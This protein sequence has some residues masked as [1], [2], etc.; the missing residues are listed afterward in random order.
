[1]FEKALAWFLGLFVATLV[2]AIARDIIP[3]GT[4]TVKSGFRVE[5][6]LS[7]HEPIP[8]DIMHRYYDRISADDP[9]YEFLPIQMIPSRFRSFSD[10]NS[11]HIITDFALIRIINETPS[12]IENIRIR[13]GSG[14]IAE[15]LT[16]DFSQSLESDTG[17]LDVGTIRSNDIVVVKIW[18]EILSN[19]SY[20]DHNGGLLIQ[21]SSGEPSYS[22]IS[23]PYGNNNTVSP[24]RIFPVL[25]FLL[26]IGA[27]LLIAILGSAISMYVE[28]RR[29]IKNPN[30]YY[31]LREE[32]EKE[33]RIKKARKEA[34]KI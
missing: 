27:C 16:G 8:F 34:D 15:I 12:D 30:L 24:R 32:F 1:M 33:V 25:Y 6:R 13:I 10:V 2:T 31:A 18:S 29:I 17:F 23:G 26:T 4:F 11:N 7:S 3:E 9:R 20:L 14:Y 22:V 19:I 5:I 28:Y 21:S